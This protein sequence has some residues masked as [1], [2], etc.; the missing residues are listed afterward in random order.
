MSEKKIVFILGSMG[1]GGA[2]RVISILSNHYIGKGCEVHI[3]TLLDSKCEYELHESIKLKYI[4]DKRK[5]R[6]SQLPNWILGIREYV[7]EVNPDKIV[8]FAARINI[9]TILSCFGLNKEIIISERNDPYYDGRSGIINILTSILYPLADKKVFQTKWAQSY[10]PKYITK[11][12]F[13][14]P[15]PIQVTIKATKK[16]ETKIVSVGRLTEQKNHKLLIHAFSKLIKSYPN[17]KLYIYGEGELRQEY[18]ATIKSLNLENNIFLPGI[19]DNIHEEIKDAKI[20]V[21]SSNYEGL[22]NALLEAMMMGLPCISTNCSGIDEY[23][24]HKENGLLVPINDSEKLYKQM[25]NLI[26]NDELEKKIRS[27]C[28]SFSNHFSKPKVI[29]MWESVIGF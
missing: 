24:I 16:S 4:G 3:I 20:F 25:K 14:I 26:E 8:S 11:K 6:I 2:E 9:I 1:K 18:V 21:L 7:K 19:I 27:N 22:S 12:S 15:N 13:V 17:Y 29:L 10:F 23:I 28:N 5:K